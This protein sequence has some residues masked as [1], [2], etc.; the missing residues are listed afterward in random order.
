MLV[1][2][3]FT[4]QKEEID[5]YRNNWEK[6]NDGSITDK[7]ILEDYEERFWADKQDYLE[8]ADYIWEIV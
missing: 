8:C 2:V 7:E 1:T 6:F 5:N 4:I 3:K